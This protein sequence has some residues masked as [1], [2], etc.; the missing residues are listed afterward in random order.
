MVWLIVIV[1]CV[2]RISIEI[3]VTTIEGLS[4]ITPLGLAIIAG[5]LVLLY[6]E[7][8]RRLREQA[9][10]SALVRIEDRLELHR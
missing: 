8:R 7:H 6:S 2:A 1:F 3:A 9:I 5:S 4:K 10:I